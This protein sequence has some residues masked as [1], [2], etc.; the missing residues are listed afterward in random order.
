[1][2][3]D[4]AVPGSKEN[5]VKITR[6]NDP[7]APV[8]LLEADFSKTPG[9][10]TYGSVTV[11]FISSDIAGDGKATVELDTTNPNLP[12]IL[13]LDLIPHRAPGQMVRINDDDSRTFGTFPVDQPFTL[14]VGLEVAATSAVVHINLFGAGTNMTCPTSNPLSPNC[15]DFPIPNIPFAPQYGAIKLYMGFPWSGHFDATDMVVTHK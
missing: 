9:T 11:F 4:G 12:P 10:G 15:S 14:S 3:I 5:W 13:H 1:V 7:T 2:I 8:S 6:A